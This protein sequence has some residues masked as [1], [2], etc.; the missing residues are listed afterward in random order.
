MKL[1]YKFCKFADLNTDLEKGVFE[2]YASTY[3]NVDLTNDVI[4]SGA[5]AK[6]CERKPKTK[7]LYQ[8]SW[9]DVLGIGD[10]R[11][12]S[13][14]LYLKGYL[15]LD[16]QKSKEV[17][18]LMKQG[19]LDSMSVGFQ[20]PEREKNISFTE[21]GERVIKECDLMEVSIVTFPANP[22]ALIQ[23]VK[24]LDIDSLKTIREAEDAL[25]DLGLS[26]KQAQHLISVIKGLEIKQQS[27]DELEL[28]TTLNQKLEKWQK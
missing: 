22:E 27:D 5:F 25:R 15:N 2:G 9:S 18:S 6:S 16:V 12:D 13:K 4:Q 23:S 17:H 26:I 10:V 3:G 24:S 14:G 11:S 1:E 28:L 21:T 7:L 19:A 20:V 8:H